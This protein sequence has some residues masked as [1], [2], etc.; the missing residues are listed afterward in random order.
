MNGWNWYRFF[1]EDARSPGELT[2]D[3]A[4]LGFLRELRD[5]MLE[6]MSPVSEA[7]LIRMTRQR[8]INKRTLDK[9]L[10]SLVEAGLIYLTDAG[11]WCDIAEREIAFR[12]EKSEKISKRNAKV[13]RKRWEKTKENQSSEIPEK[14][15]DEE[16]YSPSGNT[17]SS[18]TSFNNDTDD[19]EIEESAPSVAPLG[20][21]GANIVIGS[22][23]DGDAH[24]GRPVVSFH[25]VDDPE[26]F[27]LHRIASH[28]FIEAKDA[29]AA[30]KLLDYLVGLC[31]PENPHDLRENLHRLLSVKELSRHLYFSI[32]NQISEV[33]HA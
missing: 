20:A 25:E 3:Y 24:D 30:Q 13:S 12:E 1:F 9:M 8:G 26:E 27:F 17:P 4:T 33:S 28:D 6:R 23:Q 22:D 14:E 10:A 2:L 29:V 7:V 18:I 21:S 19:A 31:S 11:Y 15:E 5:T 32:I 16:G